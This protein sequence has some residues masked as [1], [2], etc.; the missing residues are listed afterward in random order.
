MTRLTAILRR[1]CAVRGFLV[2]TWLRLAPESAFSATLLGVGGTL[3][4]L[5]WAD[6]RAALDHAPAGWVRHMDDEPDSQASVR[7]QL[8]AR[9][10]DATERERAPR[11]GH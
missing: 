3:H 2:P 6:N 10:A 4:F 8:L 7:G 1:I 5:G 11:P 9:A